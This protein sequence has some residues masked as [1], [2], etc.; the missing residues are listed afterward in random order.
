MQPMANMALRAARQAVSKITQA[1]D[2]PD[3]IRVSSKGQNDYVTNI[4]KDVQYIIIRELKNAY[5]DHSFRGEED[6]SNLNNPESDYEWII[7]PIDGTTN[8]IHNVPHFCISI[9]CLNKGKVE[10]GVI[11]DPMRQEEFVASKGKGCTV[12]GHRARC[13]DKSSLLGA[14]IGTGGN[15]AEYAHQQSNVYQRMLTENAMVRSAGSAALDLAY[16]A[17]GRMDGVWFKGLNIWDMAAGVLMIQETGGLLGDFNGG[18]G[19][20]QSGDIVAGSPRVFK[21]LAPIVKK[22]F[23]Q[24]SPD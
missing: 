3:L 18:A 16:V 24:A 1:F 17:T 7:D 23:A 20:L 19:H 9:A 21:A 11:L 14:L 15:H 13:G 6:Q 12:N 4:D 10:H 8:F 2:R 22:N 5:P